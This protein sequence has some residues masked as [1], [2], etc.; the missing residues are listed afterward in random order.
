MDHGRLLSDLRN[1]IEVSRA[2]GSERDLDR[3]LDR[4]IAAACSLGRAERASLFVVDR[5]TAE[6]WTRRAQD[7]GQIRLPLGRGIAGAVAATGASINIPDAYAD[8]RFDRSTDIRT[9]FRTRSLLTLPLRNHRD[10]TVAVLQVLNRRDGQPFDVH[11]EDVLAALG[12][13]AAVALSLIHI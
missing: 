12:S 11:D 5:V 7:S 13:Q 1:I 4:I 10:E 2:I 8:E 6:L 3:L 9:G